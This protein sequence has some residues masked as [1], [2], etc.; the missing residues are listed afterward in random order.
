MSSETLLEPVSPWNRLKDIHDV[1]PIGTEDHA[2]L[3]EIRE[4]LNRHGKRE[5]FGV[6]LLHKHFDLAHDEMLVEETD[7]EARTLT[8]KPIATSE[9]PA[10]I[11]TIWML[12][13]GDNQAMMGCMQ[14]CGKDVQGNHG[15]F[16][17]RSRQEESPVE[18]GA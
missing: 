14:Y 3:A 2:C 11:Q 1:E 6:A 8:I 4:V 10:T 17:R 16:H 9:A 7:V 15:S 13:E 5:R 12:L 18:S